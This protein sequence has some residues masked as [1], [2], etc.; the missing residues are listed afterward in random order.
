M[1]VIG[2]HT[3]DGDAKSIQHTAFLYTPWFMMNI[4]DSPVNTNDFPMVS[5]RRAVPD[6]VTIH[7]GP[8]TCGINPIGLPSQISGPRVSTT[9]RK[10]GH[11]PFIL[12]NDPIF[13]GS[14]RL[15]GR[16]V[17]FGQEIA[18]EPK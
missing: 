12:G 3:A 4:N 8:E 7:R 6:F 17:S 16:Q 10:R 2:V 9:P 5:F 1:E 13:E 11:D 18:V 15:H 14:W